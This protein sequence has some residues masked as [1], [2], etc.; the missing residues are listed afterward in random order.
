MHFQKHCQI[1]SCLVRYR[2]ISNYQI[3]LYHKVGIHIENALVTLK[4]PSKKTNMYNSTVR[5]DHI[6]HNSYIIN[7]CN[8]GVK[9]LQ[10]SEIAPLVAQSRFLNNRVIISTHCDISSSIQ[11]ALANFC[12]HMPEVYANIYRQLLL[13]VETC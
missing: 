2:L 8:D 11:Q 4:D 9:T 13:F 6:F 7:N 1:H 3:V 5:G 12:Q 10:L